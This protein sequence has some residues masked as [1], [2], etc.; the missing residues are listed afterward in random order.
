[1]SDLVTAVTT[2]GAYGDVPLMLIKRLALS[3]LILLLPAFLSISAGN[4]AREPRFFLERGQTY[5]KAKRWD[6]ALREYQYALEIEPRC[7]DAYVGTAEVYFQRNEPA[8]G[9]VALSEAFRADWHCAEAF[10]VRAEML[11]KK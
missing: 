9:M 7:G 1:M 5:A 4:A 2:P 10:V 8:L 6:D 11:Q 3:S